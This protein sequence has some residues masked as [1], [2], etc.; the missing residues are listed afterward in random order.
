MTEED[1]LLAIIDVVRNDDAREYT[2][3]GYDLWL[4]NLIYRHLHRQNPNRDQNQAQREITALS[5]DFCAAA[6]ELCRRGILRP[7]I[8]IHGAQA[9]ESG[10]SGAWFTRFTV[11]TRLFS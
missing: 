4:P 1:A 9:T 3:Y 2:H 11:P 8:R 5:P 10:G 7:G 6:W